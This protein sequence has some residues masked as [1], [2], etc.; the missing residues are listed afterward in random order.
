VI[1]PSIPSV[2]T[3]ERDATSHLHLPTVLRHADGRIEIGMR[4]RDF[5]HVV[6]ALGLEALSEEKHDSSGGHAVRA[7]ALARVLV[8]SLPEDEQE[9]VRETCRLVRRLRRSA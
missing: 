9:E 6:T 3:T 8:G 2:P 4:R 7:L 1:R 5:H